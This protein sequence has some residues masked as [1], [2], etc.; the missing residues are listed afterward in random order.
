MY[1]PGYTTSG[2][3]SHLALWAEDSRSQLGLPAVNP[4][5]VIIYK[6][7]FMSVICLRSCAANTD[8]T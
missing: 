2:Q 7:V 6:E 8:K 5:L 1:Q 4:D 3:F